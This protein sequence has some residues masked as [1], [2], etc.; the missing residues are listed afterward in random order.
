MISN[1]ILWGNA[2]TGNG[3]NIS[4]LNAAVVAAQSIIE[5][6]PASVF[7]EDENGNRVGTTI[8][9]G[10][11]NDDPMFVKGIAVADV[12]QP[13]LGI[14]ACKRGRRQS[15]PGTTILCQRA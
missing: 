8:L 15:T 10:V 3:A 6:V 14:R 5:P 11:S 4:T 12:R 13:A 7:D 9:T 2:S 1:S